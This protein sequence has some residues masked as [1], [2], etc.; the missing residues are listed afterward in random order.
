LIQRGRQIADELGQTPGQNKAIVTT[1]VRRDEVGPNSVK[2]DIA[3]SRLI[4]LLS[5]D[6]K[7]WTRDSDPINPSDHVLMPM[8]P[9]QLTG[10]GRETASGRCSAPCSVVAT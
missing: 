8:A 10:I 6:S 4:A 5:S 3:Q 7:D 1:M 9:V 2:I